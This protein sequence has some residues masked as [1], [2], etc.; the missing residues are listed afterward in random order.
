MVM[1]QGSRLGFVMYFADYKRVLN[2]CVFSSVSRVHY[3]VKVDL[4]KAMC[5]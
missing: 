3:A 4:R 5:F 1:L 2:T